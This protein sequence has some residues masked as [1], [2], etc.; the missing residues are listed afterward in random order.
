LFT[1]RWNANPACTC[2][3]I[4][5]DLPGSKCYIREATGAAGTGRLRWLTR[6]LFKKLRVIY[7]TFGVG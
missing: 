6:G 7:F 2:E 4:I 3:A 1:K 5:I